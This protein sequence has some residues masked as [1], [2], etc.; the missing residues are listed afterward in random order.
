MKQMNLTEYRLYFS[1]SVSCA[2]HKNLSFCLRAVDN[3]N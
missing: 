1:E 2:Y 3:T